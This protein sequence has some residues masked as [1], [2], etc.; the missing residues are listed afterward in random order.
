MMVTLKDA[1]NVIAAAEQKAAELEQ[2]MNIAVADA[3]GNLIAHVRMDDAWMGSIDI[4]IK[5]AFTARAFDISTKDLA[6]LSQPGG[7][8]FGIHASN[9]GRVMIFAGGVPLKRGG[10]V[11]GA[12]GVSGGSGV[13]D[14]TVAE[15]GAAAF[16]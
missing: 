1:K 4:A 8:F 12:I 7:Q 16:S 14:Q 10:K 5:K 15:A 2:P 11:V 13:Q 3:G 6:A 9:D